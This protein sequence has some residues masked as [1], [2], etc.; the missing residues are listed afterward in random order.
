VRL[1][2]G[3]RCC[4]MLCGLRALADETFRLHYGTD[5]LVRLLLFD[6]PNFFKETSDLFADLAIFMAQ[7]FI[8][9][10]DRSVVLLALV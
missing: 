5:I 4:D 10:Q 7:I 6:R 1:E 3:D 9:P 2:H 8:L